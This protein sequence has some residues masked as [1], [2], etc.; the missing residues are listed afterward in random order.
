MIYFYVENSFFVFLEA[1][2][3]TYL[4]QLGT[5]KEMAECGF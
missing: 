4:H 5:V 1:P 2:Q 3:T